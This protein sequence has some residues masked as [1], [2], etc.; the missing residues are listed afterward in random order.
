GVRGVDGERGFAGTRRCHGEAPT[1]EAHSLVCGVLG[2]ECWVRSAGC[3]V[4]GAECWVRSVGCGVLGAE[5][6][7]RSAG[8]GVLRTE[9]CVAT[10]KGLR[11]PAQGGR[12]RPPRGDREP[13]P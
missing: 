1:R 3:G 10:P 12:P 13:A 2:A 7:V 6:W 8:C 5:C 4:P 9:C 11:R